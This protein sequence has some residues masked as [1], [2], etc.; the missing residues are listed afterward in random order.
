M[1]N[2]VRII[3]STLVPLSLALCISWWHCRAHCFTQRC[4][5]LVVTLEH[6]R[7]LCKWQTALCTTHV[8]WCYIIRVLHWRILAAHALFR[9]VSFK[10][11]VCFS[12]VSFKAM[13]PWCKGPE[14]S[15]HEAGRFAS[16]SSTMPLWNHPM[17]CSWDMLC[18]RWVLPALMPSPARARGIAERDSES[19]KLEMLRQEG[20]S[21]VILTLM[22]SESS[23]GVYR[24]FPPRMNQI[25]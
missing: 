13:S 20:I 15:M 21:V 9:R 7:A 19:R 22:S 23:Y 10:P 5:T 2:N 12:E 24:G 3:A 18:P 16:Q 14:P 11:S 25:T 4:V 8:A 17:L 6:Q 1:L